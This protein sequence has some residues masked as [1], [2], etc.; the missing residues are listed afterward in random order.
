VVVVEEPFAS[1]EDR[2]EIRR[3]GGVTIV[4]PLRRPRAERPFVD[5]AAIETVRRLLTSPQPV[6]WLYQPMMLDL[7]EAFAGAPLVYDCMDDL[8]SFAFAPRGM[9]ECEAAL[10]SHADLVLCGGRTL[11]ER[12][13]NRAQNVRL[14]P[15][16]VEY[17]HF[18]AARHLAPHPVVAAVSRPRYGYLGVIDERIDMGL[19]EALAGS[20]PAPNVVLVG[21]VV[22]IDPAILPRRANVHFTGVMPYALLPSILAGLDV[23]LMPFARNDSTRSISP[24]KTLEYLAAAVPVVSTRIPDVERDYEGL[25]TFAE[26]EGFVRACSEF[27]ANPNRE[28]LARGLERARTHGWDAIADAMWEDLTKLGVSRSGI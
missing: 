8:A 28:R 21:P 1:D 10:L 5:A 25:V 20:S 24:T 3:D 12:R 9:R 23:A 16:G 15:S 14:Y 11:Y 19:I 13:R 22:K 17:G 27:A 2:D 6:V 18:A 26:G 4:R 7:A